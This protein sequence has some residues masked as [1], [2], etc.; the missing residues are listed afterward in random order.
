MSLILP[1][2]NDA[3]FRYEIALDGRTYDLRVWWATDR[4]GP[5]LD[6]GVPRQGWLVRGVRLVRLWPLLYRLRHPL[7]PSGD[8]YLIE[9]TST[10]A[11]LGTITR[12]SLLEG[13]QQLTY[14]T[15][16]EILAIQ[17]PA[18]STAAVRF[19]EAP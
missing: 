4:G 17:P 18:T 7:R 12:D 10:L 8:L 5:R 6:L 15:R 3:A 11:D 13:K 9:K 19:V 16:A 14:L 1:V 2:I